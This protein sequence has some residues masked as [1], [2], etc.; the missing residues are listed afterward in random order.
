ML[1]HLLVDAA[2]ETGSSGSQCA[3]SDGRA[4]LTRLGRQWEETGTARSI[5]QYHYD[6]FKCSRPLS[7]QQLNCFYVTSTI[8]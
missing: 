4:S 2:C 7:F 5:S 6:R 1:Q 8:R 3:L